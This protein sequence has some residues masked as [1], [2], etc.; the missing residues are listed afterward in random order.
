M[1]RAEKKEH[2]VSV[3][4]DLFN[5][6]GFHAVGIDQIIADSGVA[7]TTLYRHFKSKDDLIVAVLR[8]AH[9][10]MT[11]QMRAAAE[12]A[13]DNPLLATFAYLTDWFATG[14]FH[15]CPFMCAAQEFCDT[16]S[17]AHMEAV[18]HKQATLAYFEALAKAE[19]YIDYRG[20]ARDVSLLHEGAISM[21]QIS[22]DPKTATR[23]RDAAV[24]LLGTY[25]K[26]G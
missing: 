25:P 10:D 23:A 14:A 21:A 2:L 20:A 1:R 12:A 24:R 6:Y 19:G 13:D 16:D 15:G 3:A 22:G 18:R 7:K 11:R 9:D 26:R 4:H 5:Q 17:P 8:R